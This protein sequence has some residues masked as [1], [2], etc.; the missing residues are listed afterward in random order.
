[1]A[2]SIVTWKTLGQTAD[3]AHEYQAR[4]PRKKYTW[5]IRAHLSFKQPTE[6]CIFNEI[7]NAR[8]S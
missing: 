4:E 2:E 5:A 1:M 8:R 6:S 7:S 3:P